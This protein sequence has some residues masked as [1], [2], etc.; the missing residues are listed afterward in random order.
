MVSKQNNKYN[1]TTI[2]TMGYGLKLLTSPAMVISAEHYGSKNYVEFDGEVGRMSCSVI[3]IFQKGYANKLFTTFKD[4]ERDEWSNIYKG[5]VMYFEIQKKY[6]ELQKEDYSGAEE[7]LKAQMKD[8]KS[9]L[10]SAVKRWKKNEN[11]NL[12][13]ENCHEQELYNVF[14]WLLKYGEDIFEIR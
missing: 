6:A 4:K 9:V 5:K 14:Y 1:N 11:P 3:E 2:T 12:G 8:I 7:R 13:G 10:K